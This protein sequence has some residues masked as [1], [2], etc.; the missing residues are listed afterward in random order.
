MKETAKRRKKDK[1]QI[2]RLRAELAINRHMIN[3]RNAPVQA[4]EVRKQ[5]QREIYEIEN[6]ETKNIHSTTQAT[7][8]RD[9][10]DNCTKAF[11]KSYKA[12]AKQ[13]WVNETY[14]AEW[15][16]GEEPTIEQGPRNRNG[17][18]P[19]RISD[20]KG[21]LKEFEKFYK[22]LFNEK[23]TDT[24]DK[25]FFLRHLAKNESRKRQRNASTRQ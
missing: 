20:S 21:I 8:S 12:Q 14:K 6:P 1:V 19:S 2:K 10:S 3:S 18:D 24:Q 17:T 23:K 22:F 5:I 16:E 7:Q 25:N 15:K 9:R 11:F 13:Q 4:V